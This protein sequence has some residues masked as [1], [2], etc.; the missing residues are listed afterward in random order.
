[1]A[2]YETLHVYYMS[3]TMMPTMCQILVVTD[4]INFLK[5]FKKVIRVLRAWRSIA[6]ARSQF[7]RLLLRDHAQTAAVWKTVAVNLGVHLHYFQSSEFN[8]SLQVY[9]PVLPRGHCKFRDASSN[10]RQPPPM[11]DQH[12]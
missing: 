2:D 6:V 5:R 4:P 11:R 10:R 12:L 3:G 1:M 9:V 8:L 7:V